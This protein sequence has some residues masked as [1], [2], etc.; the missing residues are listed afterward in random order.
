M[1]VPWLLADCSIH[2]NSKPVAFGCECRDRQPALESHPELAPMSAETVRL[3]GS[4]AGELRRCR[5]PGILGATRAR[6]RLIHRAY[7]TPASAPP[8]LCCFARAGTALGPRS[9]RRAEPESSGS[10]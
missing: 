8:G 2:L 1:R 6:R 7:T 3:T 4:P 5:R 10:N 9:R